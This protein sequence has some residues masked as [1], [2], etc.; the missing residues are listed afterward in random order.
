MSGAFALINVLADSVGPGSVGIRGDGDSP[1]FVV[2]TSLTALCFILLHTAWN[3][4][5][6]DAVDKRNY[7][8]I[9]TVVLLHFAASYLVR[10]KKLQS[11]CNLMWPGVRAF[12]CSQSLAPLGLNFILYVI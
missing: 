1:V 4:T 3:V 10:K 8:V 6:S 9:F 2:A 5:F 12:I 11:V 7:F